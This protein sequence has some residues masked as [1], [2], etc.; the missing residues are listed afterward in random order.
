MRTLPV[1]LLLLWLVSAER[2]LSEAERQRNIDS[3]EYVWKTVRDKHWDPKLNGV[4]WQTVHDELGPRIEKADSTAQARAVMAEML[5]RLKQTHFGIIPA[6]AYEQMQPGTGSQAGTVGIDVRVIRGRVLVT[7]VEKASTAGA[8]GIR[9]GWELLAVDGQELGE[10]LRRVAKFF[11]KSTLEALAGRAAVVYRLRG[12]PG[13]VVSLRLRNGQNQTVDL[14]VAR[15]GQRG[16]RAQ[17]GFF[18]PM[19]VWS[20]WRKIGGSAGY[21]AFSMFM[22]PENVMKTAAEA[23]TACLA[24]QGFII[25]LRGNPG[26][27]GAMAMGLAG[28][29]VEEKGLRLG[30]M[31]TRET[32]LRFVVNPRPV[33]YRGPLAILVDGSSASTAEIFSG[34]MKDLKRARIFGS[35]TAGAAL[36]SVIEKLPNGDGFQFAIANY[37]SEGGQPLEGIGVIPDE[38]VELTRET[39]LEGRDTVLEAALNWIKQHN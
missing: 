1:A 11:E 9:P 17:F 4:D 2:P 18:P 5:E 28:W 27:I 15:T 8:K 6:E 30:A 36:P 14:L 7:S 16:V 22:D 35:R 37:I 34:G 21:L 33:T 10:V 29:F 32:A 20:E 31:Q 39:L 19:Y 3:F 23:I 13:S 12:P 38:E 24:C 25:D 26:G